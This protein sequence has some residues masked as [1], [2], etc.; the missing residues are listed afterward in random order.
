MSIYFIKRMYYVY[1][2][3]KVFR[4]LRKLIVFIIIF[5]K[6]SKMYRNFQRI[7]VKFNINEVGFNVM[8]RFVQS[9]VQCIK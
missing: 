8:N 1:K 5:R 3:N 6:V 7:S 4:K 9:T 2:Y